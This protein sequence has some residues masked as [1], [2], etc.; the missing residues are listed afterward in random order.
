VK[1][2]CHSTHT[3]FHGNA[4]TENSVATVSNEQIV[5]LW[6]AALGLI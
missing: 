1:D 3:P 4:E 5:E 2:E 6:R